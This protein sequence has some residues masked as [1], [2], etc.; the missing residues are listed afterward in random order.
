MSFSTV[1]FTGP[2]GGDFISAS[3]TFT[4]S[5]TGNNDG[6]ITGTWSWS[7]AYQGF[8][9]SGS[10]AVSGTISGT[11]GAAGPW[12]L[13]LIGGGMA[14]EGST[15]A[16]TN[17]QF[18]L[19]AGMGFDIR[20]EIGSDYGGNYVYNDHFDLSGQFAAAGPGPGGATEG[21]DALTGTGGADTISA[22]GG[23]DTITA[24]AGNDTVDGGAGVDT[25]VFSDVRAN[26]AITQTPGTAHT[27]TVAH[28]SLTGDG[29]D[30]LVN[31]ERLQFADSKV[32][33]D[34]DADGG[35]A[36]RLYQAAFNRVPDIGGLGFQMNALDTGFTLEQVAGNFILSPEFQATYGNV[37]DT[38]F[39]T[40]LYQN[41]LHRAPDTGGLQFHLDEMHV[42][43]QTR[44]MEL[45]HF[46]ES[47]ENQAN[48]LGAIQ[49]G[50]VYVF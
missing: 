17:G 2:L 1:T 4:A 46:S 26:Y 48:V 19:S 37:D 31:V 41:V 34:L 7:G 3:G 43:G 38:Q 44:A 30:T 21:A 50:M 24:G 25:A 15:L 9:A 35:M 23:N 6:S 29:T 36:Y 40:L 45:V 20:S 13:H 22:L 42:Q 47:P 18:M 49:G 11:G 5:I 27:W 14:D 28:N 10:E 39:L 32:A 16:F 33:I 12:T 8:Y